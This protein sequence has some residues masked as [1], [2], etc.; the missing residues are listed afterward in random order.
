VRR[1]RLVLLPWVVYSPLLGLPAHFGPPRRL[2]LLSLLPFPFLLPFLLRRLLLCRFRFPCLYPR[3]PLYFF[4]CL[5]LCVAVLSLASRVRQRLS[6]FSF[7]VCFLFSL[8]PSPPSATVCPAFPAVGTLG[9]SSPS[10]SGSAVVL[11]RRWF[12]SCASPA[13]PF[14]TAVPTFSWLARLFLSLAFCL[15]LPPCAPRPPL[16]PVSFAPCLP[17]PVGLLVLC[18]PAFPDSAIARF[19]RFPGSPAPPRVLAGPHVLIA[20]S[21]CS[22]AALEFLFWC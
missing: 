17:Q 22:L 15:L 4:D 8:A 5:G 1:P 9:P 13:P 12:S 21:S 2:L 18:F 19:S 11:A 6:C 3:G 10:P 20:I 16:L 14:L 7:R